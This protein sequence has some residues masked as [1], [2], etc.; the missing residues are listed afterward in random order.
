[1]VSMA[2]PVIGSSPDET[3]VDTPGDTR[4]FDVA[5]YVAALA[6]NPA[7]SIPHDFPEWLKA[8]IESQAA[9]VRQAAVEFGGSL[10]NDPNSPEAKREREERADAAINAQMA[11][12]Q[13]QERAEWAR[14]PSTVGGVT[15]TGEEWDKLAKRLRNDDEL[16][17]RVLTAFQKRGISETEAE[18]RYERVADVAEIMA[19][20]PSQRTAEE[21]ET[22][23]KADADPTFKQD[24]T[25]MKDIAAPASQHGAAAKSP[26]ELNRQFSGAATATVSEKPAAPAAGQFAATAPSSGLNF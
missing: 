4:Q 23:R 22:V 15:M 16:R 18:A 25:D 21:K 2:A 5:T 10:T 20:P 8:H 7:A 13:Q 12:L 6:M 24:M 26:L 17:E 19:I 1:M 3:S 14:T 9:V 11:I